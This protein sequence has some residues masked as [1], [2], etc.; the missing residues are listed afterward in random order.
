MPFIGSHYFPGPGVAVNVNDAALLA[1]PP[2]GG[3]PL[4]LVG[5]A[6]DGA[7]QTALPITTP[8]QA[9]RVLKGGDLLQAALLALAT[10]PPPATLT[11]I[12]PEAAT[13][14]TSAIKDS[15]STDQIA[16]TTTSYGTVA[17]SAKWQ[18][19]ASTSPGY[20]VTQGL[21]FSG[22]GGVTF[23]NIG[24]LTVG[25]IPLTLQYT[26][27]GTAPTATV[28]D[29]AIT[30]KATTSDT[31]GT[32]T[33][34]TGMTVQQL[35][36]QINQLPGW[37]A[38]VTDPNPND[39]VLPTDM[40]PG[41]TTASLPALLDN[42]SA[43]T[44]STT[45]PT[46]LTAHVA[47]VVRWFNGQAGYFTAVRQANATALATATSWTYATGGT[48]PSAT[49][50]NW[51]SAYTVAQT[52]PGAWIVVPVS[53]SSA[54]WAMN[55]AH[56]HYMASL[57]APRRGYMGDALGATE[58]TEITDA[59]AL[60][61]NRSTLLWPGL[62]GTNYNGQATTFAP[63]LVAASVGAARAGTV[64]DRALTQQPVASI[65]TGLE[66]PT[67]PGMVA[68]G[69][70]GGVAVLTRNPQ[71]QIVLSQDRT[72]WLQSPAVDKVENSTGLVIDT[73]TVALNTLLAQFLGQPLDAYL[74]E[75]ATQELLIA[76]QDFYSLGYL[77][78]EP[79]A[80]DVALQQSGTTAIT[81]SVTLYPTTP[82]NY[83]TV[84]LNAVS[85]AAA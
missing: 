45:T 9:V 10:S 61:S 51:Q 50:T 69:L 63:Y 38:T 11:V 49:N 57:G 1:P 17:N 74:L 53:S 34:T 14:A 39:L 83:I 81:G 55:D 48:T 26:G 58:A 2:Q 15:G 73:I 46:S 79:S 54:I 41:T 37:V 56:C 43:V 84:T 28:T 47:A 65:F 70:T 25:L 44:V 76:L 68:Q 59:G 72:T 66:Q 33:F 35:A 27:T 40:V 42:V 7:P 8:S 20:S 16:L 52:L 24:P 62:G 30:V 18:V 23:P 4:L 3:L 21:D 5:P 6:T 82:T 60:N 77:V 31:G 71:G 19:A 85:A 64:I 32:V 29:A 12:R 13:P 36:N 80:G 75:T 78:V 67:T 22:P